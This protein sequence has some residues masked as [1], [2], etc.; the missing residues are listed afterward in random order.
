MCNKKP[1]IISSLLISAFRTTKENKL[2]KFCQSWNL[3]FNLIKLKVWSRPI[4]HWSDTLQLRIFKKQSKTWK[5]FFKILKSLKVLK[6]KM[7]WCLTV[8]FILVNGK[9]KSV[10]IRIKSLNKNMSESLLILERQLIVI[11]RTSQ[12]GITLQCLIMNLLINKMM[13]FLMKKRLTKT[14]CQSMNI[15]I[16]WMLSLHV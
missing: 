6:F 13:L 2:F 3:I 1:N 4:L 11:K 10:I 9:R 8:T 12:L 15:S 5:I 16:W 14:N 7:N